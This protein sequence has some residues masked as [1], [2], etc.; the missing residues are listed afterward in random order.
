[1]FV[2]S[3]K[4]VRLLF[5]KIARLIGSSIAGYY[6]IEMSVIKLVK[7]YFLEY[8][9][10][11]RYKRYRAIVNKIWF[12][13][14]LKTDVTLAN[15]HAVGKIPNRIDSLKIIMV[16]NTRSHFNQLTRNQVVYFNVNFLNEL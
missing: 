5:E 1:M 14:F 7:D 2:A 16:V 3:N 13:P 12:V 11:D 15:F 8:F 6:L 4:A 10:G 9:C